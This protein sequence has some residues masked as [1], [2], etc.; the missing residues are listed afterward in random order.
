MD[1]YLIRRCLFIK[2]K[3]NL[4]LYVVLLIKLLFIFLRFKFNKE[5]NLNEI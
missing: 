2:S 5:Y 3:N 4:D 1:N